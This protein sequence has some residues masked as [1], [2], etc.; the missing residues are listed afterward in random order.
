MLLLHRY[1]EHTK[2]HLWKELGI[3]LY[4]SCV[5][6]SQLEVLD[7]Y[8]HNAFLLKAKDVLNNFL[9]NHIEI[10]SFTSCEIC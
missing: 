1:L 9:Y 2:F 3:C 5:L 6:G 7:D 8:L 4:V 10:I